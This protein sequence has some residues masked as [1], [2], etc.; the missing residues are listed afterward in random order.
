[1]TLEGSEAVVGNAM[2]EEGSR[3]GHALM[4]EDR[5]SAGTS[6]TSA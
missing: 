4:E 2:A 6:S 5:T 1:M 3:R